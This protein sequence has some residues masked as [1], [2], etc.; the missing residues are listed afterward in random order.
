MQHYRKIANKTRDMCHI[1]INIFKN[2]HSQNQHEQHTEGREDYVFFINE[3]T[4]DLILFAAF[5][6]FPKLPCCVTLFIN[7]V[8]A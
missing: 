4:H 7:D 2:R 6:M 3:R 8:F 5:P 1:H